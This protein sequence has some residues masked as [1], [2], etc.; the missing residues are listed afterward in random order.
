MLRYVLHTVLFFTLTILTQ[1]G[2]IIYVV[3]LFLIRKHK[4]YYRLKRFTLFLLL[5][6][7]FTFLLVPNVSSYFGRK[8]IIDS[9]SISSHSFVTKLLN[10]NYVSVEMYE[11]LTDI[12]LELNKKFPEI[13]LVYLDAN[14]PFFDGF[15]LLPHLSHNDGKKID[16]AFIYEKSDG[17]LSNLKKSRS[18]YG[19]FA[20]PGN[21]EFDQN[22]ACKNEGYWQYDFPKYLTLGS[23]NNELFFSNKA[24][25]L[26]I[27]FIADHT[28]VQKV[29]VEPHL[30][31]RLQLKSDK[32]RFQGC[33][34]VRHDDHIHFQIR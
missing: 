29:F 34:S 2:G 32:I 14:F 31:K 7:T 18:G 24:N 17:T 15:P 10:R 13:K 11:V 26:L 4:E 8:K 23:I 9:K 27:N 12:S 6:G 3:S 16:I 33:H 22:T 5:Y 1:I 25:N 19:V 30:K 21:H 28:K 20:N